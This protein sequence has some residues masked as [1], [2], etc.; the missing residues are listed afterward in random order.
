MASVSSSINVYTP[1]ATLGNGTRNSIILRKPSGRLDTTVPLDERARTNLLEALL[2]DEQTTL[3]SLEKV[4]I[5]ID[6][7]N[8]EAPDNGEAPPKPRPQWKLSGFQGG[9]FAEYALT[10]I[11]DAT[12]QGDVSEESLN[13][14]RNTL[15]TILQSSP[16]HLELTR[17]LY[18]LRFSAKHSKLRQRFV[19]DDVTRA[20][21]VALEQTAKSP[22]KILFP[23]VIDSLCYFIAD[24]RLSRGVINRFYAT[25]DE[26]ETTQTRISLALD[27][28]VPVHLMATLKMIASLAQHRPDLCNEFRPKLYELAKSARD[29]VGS[30]AVKALVTMNAQ[31]VTQDVYICNTLGYLDDILPPLDVEIVGS[32]S[33]D[34][35]AELPSILQVNGALNEDFIRELL[36]TVQS[37][38][39]R[40][41]MAAT[42]TLLKL[43]R[44]AMVRE[45]CTRNDVLDIFV[46]QLERK[47]TSLLAAY[48]L[49]KCLEYNMCTSD[50]CLR[51]APVL[52]SMLEKNWF[53]DAIGRVEG[54]E[55]FRGLM[56]SADLRKDVIESDIVLALIRMLAGGERHQT[57]MS[58]IC[59][60]ILDQKPPLDLKQYVG[61]SIANLQDQDKDVRM[62]GVKVISALAQTA[63]GERAIKERLNNILGILSQESR[64]LSRSQIVGVPSVLYNL[65]KNET[66][67]ELIRDSQEFTDWKNRRHNSISDPQHRATLRN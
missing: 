12:S 60:N 18:V 1:R 22:R 40:E 67:R 3:D 50:H 44:N 51:A 47:K 36:S 7:M 14:V 34:N 31:Q 65:A 45:F 64:T 56:T 37:R 53:D 17:A 13:G 55:I 28:K 6:S 8:Y 9:A 29:G 26:T 23:L 20:L 48:A 39:V 58:L 52:V 30:A 32:V 63:A 11:N 66:L 59:I 57:R 38:N 35:I 62:K 15:C 49:R 16:D 27:V 41:R 10:V 2:R 33:S 21:M 19:D 4:L 43:C 46:K 54:C 5:L 24:E 25:S 61:D 42:F